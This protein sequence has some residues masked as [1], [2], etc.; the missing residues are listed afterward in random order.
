MSAQMDRKR[1]GITHKPMGPNSRAAEAGRRYASAQESRWLRHQHP[2]RWRGPQQACAGH[3]NVSH[4]VDLPH[5][6]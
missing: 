2:G 3:G 4:S 1:D 5:G 6:R